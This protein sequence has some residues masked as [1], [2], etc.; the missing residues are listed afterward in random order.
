MTASSSSGVH[1][2]QGVQGF[3]SPPHV[4]VKKSRERLHPLHPLH[5][6]NAGAGVS[7]SRSRSSAL[8]KSPPTTDSGTP[9][10]PPISPNTGEHPDRRGRGLSILDLERLHRAFRRGGRR[11]SR[12]EAKHPEQ[13]ELFPEAEPER[14]GRLGVQRGA[15]RLDW[16]QSVGP[17]HSGFRGL[18]SVGVREVCGIEATPIAPSPA[19]AA[20]R[21]GV[22][23]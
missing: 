9:W 10:P 21:G 8:Q 3:L 5:P 23:R 12:P 19:G 15:E 17:I 4:R 1:G 22:S 13:G 2:V 18:T 20:D 7:S 16:L 6:G 14:T 11:S